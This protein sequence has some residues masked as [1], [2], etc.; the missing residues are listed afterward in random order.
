VVVEVGGEEVLPLVLADQPWTA[1]G[2]LSY[3]V[4]WEPPDLEASQLEDPPLAHVLA[5][6][7]ALG[8]VGR[9]AATLHGAVGGEIADEDGFLV[10]P[11]DLL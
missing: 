4:R 5:R 9:L 3:H 6:S 7:R 10:D 1:G 11:G 2:A 8:V